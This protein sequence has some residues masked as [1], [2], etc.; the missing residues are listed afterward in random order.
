MPVIPSDIIFMWPSTNAS[1]PAGW[2][3]ETNLDDKFIQ[4]SPAAGDGDLTTARG[5]ANH[6]HNES[7]SHTPTQNSHTHTVSSNTYTAPKTDPGTLTERTSHSHTSSTSAG[8]TGTNQS[9]S[10][11]VDNATNDLSFVRVIFIK[12]N[13]TPTG[14]PSNAYAFFESDSLPASWTRV[15]GNRYVKGAT[16]GGDG[17][18]TGGSNTHTHTS[19]SHTHTQNSHS[20]AAANSTNATGTT[21]DCIDDPVIPRARSTHVH[22]MSLNSGTPTN[23]AFTVTINSGDSEPVYKK[24]NLINNGTGAAD[25][26]TSIVGL[27]GG[28][29]AAIP[30]D[31]ERVTGMDAMFPKNANANGESTVTT[32]GG[33]TH[34]H[35]TNGCLP[36]Q[37]THNHGST[38]NGVDD[39]GQTGPDYVV[40]KGKGV[41]TDLGH[42]HTTWTIGST[43]ATNN[44][45]T[46]T[47]AANS[48]ESHYPPYRRTIF[49]RYAPAAA[50]TVPGWR[51]MQGMGL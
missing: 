41:L 32:G 9:A 1:I 49:V 39:T 8:A 28:T 46:V 19:P 27:W 10:I 14:V 23:Q 44:S 47:I 30:A 29:N 51:M 38:D 40:L 25:L 50:V 22:S 11:L 16:A 48:S 33:T 43:V 15:Q 6:S 12:S 34:T 20:H 45:A 31:W 13:G 17:G 18:G 37:N 21:D 24:L 26:P 5:A 36:V 7:G 35:T 3:R 4:G 42:A 2:S